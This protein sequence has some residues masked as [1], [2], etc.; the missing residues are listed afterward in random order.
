MKNFTKTSLLISLILWLTGC[1]TSSHQ[2]QFSNQINIAPAIDVAYDDVIKNV[3][4][5]I[6][7]NVRWGG[8]IIAVED[9]Q[10]ITRLTVLAFPLNE[11]GQPN[12]ERGENFIGGRFIVETDSFKPD[13]SNRFITVYGQISN[14]EVLKNG[15]L[16]KTI[17]VITAIEHQDW[18]KLEQRYDSDRIRLP[19]NGLGFGLRVGPARF[20]YNNFGLYPYANLSA[21]FNPYYS[22]RSKKYRGRRRH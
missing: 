20:G 17:P 6:G 14:N 2:S 5:H 15:H 3:P 22:V 7:V 13:E 9:T 16:T 21:Y 8:Q 1:A 4:A 11:K 19:Y 10:N 18:N 12:H